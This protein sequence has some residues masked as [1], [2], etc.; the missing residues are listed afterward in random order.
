MENDNLVSLLL[1]QKGSDFFML[2]NVEGKWWLMPRRNIITAIQLYQPSTIKGKILKSYFPFLSRYKIVRKLSGIKTFK[3]ELNKLLLIK[4]KY[5]FNCEG[6]E[7]SV[8]GGTPSS[9]QKITMQIYKGSKILGYCKFSDK[10]ELK[11]IFKQEEEILNFL[12]KKGVDQI[13]SCLFSGNF[14]NNIDFFVQTTQKTN[15]SIQPNKWLTYHE[16]FLNQLHNKTKQNI[17]FEN[18]DFYNSLRLLKINLGI[19]KK[20]HN[21]L[22]LSSVN[23]LENY[24]KMKEVNFSVCHGDFTPWNM[25]IESKKLFVFDFEY[26]KKTFP[27]FLDRY[28]FYTQVCIH[29]NK[30]NA[31]EIQHNYLNKSEVIFKHSKKS[32]FLFISYLLSIISLY[33]E[34]EKHNFYKLH[35]TT[36][37]IELL[38]LLSKKLI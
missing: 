5:L 21:D 3:L 24:Y 13:P 19:L 29:E 22:I 12:Q 34:R 20:Q 35:E 36:I 6:I 26:A 33:L 25:I 23:F 16:E 38:S 15:S 28:H 11:N 32:D 2:K 10:K 7:F 1:N 9:H 8:F 37:W 17:L 18:S 30:W 27:P 4:L 14:H 31:E